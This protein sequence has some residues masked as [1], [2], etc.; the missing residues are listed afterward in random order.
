MLDGDRSQRP[1]NRARVAYLSFGIPLI[2]LLLTSC[3]APP[4][5]ART[6]VLSTDPGRAPFQPLP[7][8]AGDT[9]GADPLALAPRLYGI[10]G[11]VEGN[12]SQGVELLSETAGR[13]VVLFTQVG[14]PD[15]AVRGQR[16]RLELVPAAAGW[17]LTWVGRQVQC[18]SGRGH[19]DWGSAPCR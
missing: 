17:R 1:S 9:T 7:L 8:P 15:D 19:Q 14:L 5:N 18:R 6:E 10:D 11:P 12:Y 16:Y 3:A 2:V 13:Q 4:E